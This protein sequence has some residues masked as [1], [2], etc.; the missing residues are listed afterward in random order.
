MKQLVVKTDVEVAALQLEMRALEWQIT[1]LEDEH[2]ELE[3][4]IYSVPVSLKN[5]SSR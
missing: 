2:T 3:K 4:H 1:S 5:M